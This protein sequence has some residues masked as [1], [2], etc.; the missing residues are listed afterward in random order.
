MMNLSLSWTYQKDK[1]SFIVMFGIFVLNKK[2]LFK[3]YADV[4]NYE[5]FKKFQLYIYIYMTCCVTK[6]P[7][8]S[9][10][11][12]GILSRYLLDGKGKIITQTLS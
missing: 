1:V 10:N 12:I 8:L 3:Y 11:A 5:N 6:A 2:I 7:I 4:E 9:P